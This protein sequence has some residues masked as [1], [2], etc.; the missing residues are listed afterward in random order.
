MRRA[1]RSGLISEASIKAVL[2]ET[3]GDLFLAACAL[4]CTVRELDQYIRRS[5][6]LQVFA[7][8]VE[9]VKSD[10]GYDRMSAEQFEAQVT[11][12]SRSYKLDGLNE[13]HTL[14][15]MPIGESAAMAKVKLDAA[16]AL[17]G[18][19]SQTGHGGEAE[20]ALAE[21]NQLYQA[22]APRI[23]E[24]RTTVVTL[25]DERVAPPHTVESLADR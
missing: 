23:R 19:A 13:I 17:R 21:L 2:T 7:S 9:Q 5:P 10:P 11:I 12:L 16:V 15:M 24:I 22:N 3:K 8:T 6:L 1:M 14:A 18:G 20:A 25:T 4:D